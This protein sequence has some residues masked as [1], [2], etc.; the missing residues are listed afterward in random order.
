MNNDNQ[1]GASKDNRDE[2]G[3]EKK[4]DTVLEELVEQAWEAVDVSWSYTMDKSVCNF[5]SP[6]YIVWQASE[7]Y[8]SVC[9]SV[10]HAWG[11]GI[12]VNPLGV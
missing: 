4:R 8:A 9:V 2:A 5:S 10:S 12:T 6:R 3:T 11:I 7:S 1:T